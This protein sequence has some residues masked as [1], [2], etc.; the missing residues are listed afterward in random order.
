MKSNP[1]IYTKKLAI[2]P[3]SIALV[4][5]ATEKFM[6]ETFTDVYNQDII[7]DFEALV[8][9]SQFRNDSRNV[10][11]CYT[12]EK[13]LTIGV[14]AHEAV[15]MTNRIF[16]WIGQDLDIKKDE[17]YAY[18]LEHIVEFLVESIGFNKLKK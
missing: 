1:I 2:Y 3:I 14:I 4:L 9:T 13:S 10:V 16:N 15:H 5:N 17:C 8:G 7:K 12:V 11:V 18:L 6:N